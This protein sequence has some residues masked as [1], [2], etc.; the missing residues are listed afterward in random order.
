MYTSYSVAAVVCG[1]VFPLLAILSVG[2]RL[3][4]RR[5]NSL[6]LGLDDYAVIVALVSITSQY[7]YYVMAPKF[8]IWF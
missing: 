5:L 2:L 6:A 7:R 8:R 4:A 1:A 3:Y